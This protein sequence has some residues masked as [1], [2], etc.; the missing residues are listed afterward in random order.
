MWTQCW[1]CLRS[2]GLILMPTRIS[3]R[4]FWSHCIP[5]LWLPASDSEGMFTFMGP[6][7]FVL[8]LLHDM[9]HGLS[10][11]PA[12]PGT[13]V[14]ASWQVSRALLSFEHTGQGWQQAS[15]WLPIAF[16]TGSQVKLLLLL[17]TRQPLVIEVWLLS[18][19]YHSVECSCLGRRDKLV[20]AEITH[21]PSFFLHPSKMKLPHPLLHRPP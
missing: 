18:C 10:L 5:G 13:W 17:P 7:S 1:V 15:W 4:T 8:I 16:L 20:K 19:L 21:L 9:T 6:Q 3:R 11:A 12:G 2:V 14:A